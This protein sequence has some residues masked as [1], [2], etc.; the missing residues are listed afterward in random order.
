MFKTIQYVVPGINIYIF[1]YNKQSI[2][3][4]INKKFWQA[5]KKNSKIIEKPNPGSVHTCVYMYVVYLYITSI[6]LLNSLL[7][8]QFNFYLIYTYSQNGG[9]APW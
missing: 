7:L 5:R 3:K 6:S 9:G 4:K 2:K 1:I 8:F